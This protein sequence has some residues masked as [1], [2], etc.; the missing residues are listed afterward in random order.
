MRGHERQ[1]DHHRGADHLGRGSFH[2]DGSEPGPVSYDLGSG[3]CFHG[4]TDW[5]RGARGG[6]PPSSDPVEYRQR[7]AVEC[8]I[9][10]EASRSLAPREGV[11]Q[12]HIPPRDQMIRRKRPRRRDRSRR[13]SRSSRQGLRAVSGLHPNG[14]RPA[15]DATEVLSAVLHGRWSAEGSRADHQDDAFA[16][17]E[18]GFWVYP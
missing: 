4:S 2:A 14:C 12:R 18:N 15:L 3:S 16:M 7:H 5:S 10:E 9:N 8:G 1:R 17:H 6:R 13:S 11:S